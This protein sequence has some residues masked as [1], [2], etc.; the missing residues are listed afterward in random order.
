MQWPLRLNDPFWKAVMGKVPSPRRAS[1]ATPHTSSSAPVLPPLSSKVKKLWGSRNATVRTPPIRHTA[2]R[3]WMLRSTMPG[4]TL[5]AKSFVPVMVSIRSKGSCTSRTEPSPCP[6]LHATTLRQLHGLNRPSSAD[7]NRRDKFAGD[8]NGTTSI[9]LQVM[10]SDSSQHFSDA[11][12]KSQKSLC[13]SS[14]NKRHK[15]SSETF[16]PSQSR[17]NEQGH[18]HITILCAT[19]KNL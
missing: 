18:S 3:A 10:E 19:C 14:T 1:Q 11:S 16:P 6:R 7:S 9:N 8:S 12:P 15:T 2:C 5:M 13:S 4:A 17:P